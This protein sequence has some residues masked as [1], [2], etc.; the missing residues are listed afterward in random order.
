MTWG[1]EEWKGC[2]EVTKAGKMCLNI[3]WP[4]KKMSH[5]CSLYTGEDWRNLRIAPE[6]SL[7]VHEKHNSS[8]PQS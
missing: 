4:F 6:Y 7:G 2:C 1:W 5:K 8:Y 3:K